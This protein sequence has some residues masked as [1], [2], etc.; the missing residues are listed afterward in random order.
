MNPSLP[1]TLR[2]LLEKRARFEMGSRD[3]R[4]NHEI[5]DAVLKGLWFLTEACPCRN[6]AQLRGEAESG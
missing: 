3:L 1:L 4:G 5:I 6:Q 2:G